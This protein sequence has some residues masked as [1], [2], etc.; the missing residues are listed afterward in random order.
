MNNTIQ[1][2]TDDE[3]QSKGYPVTTPDRVVYENG[4]TVKD[5]LKN[6]VKYDV[7]GQATAPSL[8]LGYDDREIKKQINA[9]EG[10][11]DIIASYKMKSN[12]N[13]KNDGKADTTIEFNKVLENENFIYL[14]KGT[15]KVSDLNISNKIIIGELG[16][17]ILVDTLTDKKEFSILM[18][19]D[20]YIKN[21][22]FEIKHGSTRTTLVS[23]QNVS[24]GIFENC[25]FISE[26]GGATTSHTPLD[27]YRNNQNIIFENCK[28][29]CNHLNG[30]GG[31]WIRN[32]DSSIEKTTKNIVFN[33]CSC[34]KASGDEIL[35]IW[36]W[37]GYVENVKFSNCYFGSS[38]TA[39]NPSHFFSIGMTGNLK[40]VIFENSIIDTK[41]NITTI[42]NSIF[43]TI[44]DTTG[45]MLDGCILDGLTI[46]DCT[47]KVNGSN[48]SGCVI[49][50]G[51]N[52]TNSKNLV[53]DNCKIIA[54]TV[55]Q[56]IVGKYDLIN[57]TIEIDEATS[58]IFSHLNKIKNNSISATKGKLLG[59]NSSYGLIFEGNEVKYA[60]DSNFI[61]AHY[62]ADFELTFIN[63]TFKFNTPITQFIVCNDNNLSPTIKIINNKFTHFGMYL[64]TSNNTKLLMVNN[65][66]NNNSST[67]GSSVSKDGILNNFINSAFKP[68]G[69]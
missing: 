32:L 28:I 27:L 65:D 3:K 1:L 23:L 42:G 18:S 29:T 49:F 13:L 55:N 53:I 8:N 22:I 11:L 37:R 35:A 14:K 6:N 25:E 61:V 68:S 21:V 56:V 19:G 20:I 63:N 45:S 5:K 43:K 38:S 39:K 4:K 16:S 67:I 59:T 34:Y 7:V 9:I 12:Y 41:H 51:E 46:R 40:R 36:G 2:Y 24:K 33:N 54:G 30:T 69:L 31:I 64:T 62:L 50:R 48:T 26:D 58:G 66:I 57:C 10:Q 52:N 47:I 60:N 44:Y 15:Y 17:R